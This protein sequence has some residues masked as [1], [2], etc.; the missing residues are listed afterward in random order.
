M[1]LIPSD[2][3]LNGVLSYEY[4]KR[5]C[6]DAAVSDPEVVAMMVEGGNAIF[7]MMNKIAQTL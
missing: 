7:M 2:D 6:F 5:V 3:G 4:G 1:K